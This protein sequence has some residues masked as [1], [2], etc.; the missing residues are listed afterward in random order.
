MVTSFHQLNTALNLEKIGRGMLGGVPESSGKRTSA[1]SPRKSK[2]SWKKA[3]NCSKSEFETVAE[4]IAKNVCDTAMTSQR[5]AVA[6]VQ[7]IRKAAEPTEEEERGS[8]DRDLT[9]LIAQL[10]MERRSTRRRFDMD[11]RQTGKREG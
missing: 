3:T 5:F 7:E 2:T 9:R 4:A 6:A 1:G 8:S 10:L 11:Q